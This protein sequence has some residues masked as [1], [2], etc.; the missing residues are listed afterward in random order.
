MLTELVPV[1][2]TRPDGKTATV[3][4]TQTR[5][6]TENITQQFQVQVPVFLPEAKAENGRGEGLDF[7]PAPATSGSWS[8]LVIYQDG[9]VRTE[10]FPDKSSCIQRRQEL[11]E[12]PGVLCEECKQK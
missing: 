12:Q 1:T 11:A 7:A 2:I 10:Y 9:S 8:M 6:V 5:Q 4:Q 3:Y